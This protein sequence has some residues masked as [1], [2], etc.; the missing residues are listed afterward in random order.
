[1]KK[2]FAV[3]ISATLL[4]TGCGSGGLSKASENSF[5][6]GNG[7][8]VVIDAKDRQIA[9]VISG[10]TLDGS[11]FSLDRSKFTVINVWASWCAPCRAEAPIFQDFASKN[12]N[13]SFVGILTRDNLSA[14]RAFTQRFAISFP[15]LI[16][17]SLIVKFR[18]SLTPNAIP[19]TLVIDN[20]GRIAARISG[21]VTVAGLKKVLEE[22]VGAPVNA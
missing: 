19:T 3:A 17:D 22:V 18:G 4:L 16:D 10:K 6:S 9:P 1:M 5:V 13:I 2:L 14:A 20:K 11:T 15:S 7:A 8:A 12:S 21:A